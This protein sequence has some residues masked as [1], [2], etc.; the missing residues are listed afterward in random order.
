MKNLPV[1]FVWDPEPEWMRA[2]FFLFGIIVAILAYVSD[3]GELSEKNSEYLAAIL[4]FGITIVFLSL[5]WWVIIKIIDLLTPENRHY[6]CRA[7]WKQM[8][9]DL[10]PSY[11]EKLANESLDKGDATPSFEIAKAYFHTKWVRDPQ[12]ITGEIEYQK[13]PPYDLF[14]QN[15]TRSVQW[16][17]KASELKHPGAMRMLGYCYFE[18]DKGVSRDVKRGAKLIGDAK[19]IDPQLPCIEET[20]KELNIVYS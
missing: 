11:V 13:T 16:L 14:P 9:L 3:T 15:Y 1:R 19:K 5:L 18:N 10:T 17:K 20:I 7:Y 6:L 8:G 12:W 2:V 4:G